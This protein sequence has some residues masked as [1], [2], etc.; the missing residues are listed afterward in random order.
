MPDDDLVSVR[1]MV[2]DVQESIDF[3]TRH[4]GFSVRHS[5]L[6]AFADVVR[7]SLRLLLAGPESSAGRP[8]PDGRRPGPGGWNR[9]H[10][11]VD[12]IAAE[13]ERLRAAGLAFRNDP[14][15]VSS[16]SHALL[17]RG[18]RSPRPERNSMSAKAI[19][20]LT[21][22]LFVVLAIVA[23]LVSGETPSTDDSPQEIV[24]FYL[25][26]DASQAVAS[27]LLALGCVALIFF[28]G[29][30]RRALRAAAGDEGGLSTVVLLGGLVIA[31]GASIFAGIGFTLG[32]AAD[33]LPP[34]AILTLNA[35]NSDMFF[36]VAVGTAV[37]NLALALAV[38]RHGG[39][40]RP[41]GWVA[42]VIGIAG[43]TPLGFFAFL[44]TGIVII[45][46]SVALAMKADT[47]RESPSVANP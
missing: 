46:A 1:Y 23:F 2:N 34:E 7:G 19:G 4:F 32:D 16:G 30:L 31:V 35:L 24:D 18:Q 40:P 5:A 3:Y 36:T 15:E 26:N 47:S 13:V 37:F 45:W 8:M 42:L 44:A 9:I 20:P 21:G 43:L 28:L 38:L 12:D 17:G 39:L 41:L 6:P 11:I 22:I 10:L 27:A 25:D 14:D 33:D 29:S